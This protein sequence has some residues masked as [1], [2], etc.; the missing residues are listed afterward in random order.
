VLSYQLTHYPETAF[1]GYTRV[2]GTIA[3]YLRVN[4]LCEPSFTVADFGC[5]RGAH[6]DDPVRI[7]RQLRVL[8]GKVAKVIGLDIDP[9]ARTN[10][11][12]DEFHLL[13]D[14]R[15]PMLD[16]SVDLCIAD[17][18]LEHL[19]EP[20]DFFSECR[21]VLRTDGYLCIR[22]PNV[23]SYVG[24]AARIL[25]NRI[26]GKLLRRVQE[27]RKEVDVFPTLY[28]CNSMP[29]LRGRLTANGFR[30]VVYGHEAE[31]S[32]LSFARSAYRFGAL[33]QRFSPNQLR[34]VIF[35]FAQA[36]ERDGQS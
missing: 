28:R 18:V 30:H 9:V 13:T 31:P 5:G 16:S 23:W 11:F 3:F 35:A 26:H 25:S 2:D 32:Y 27:E 1:G 8:R 24:I 19:E 17:T 21:R 33:H 12:I 20:D 4:S 22:T 34:P 29:R 7:R 15:W 10:P 6:Q 14:P 36:V